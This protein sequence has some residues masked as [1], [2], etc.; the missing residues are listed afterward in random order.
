MATCTL[1]KAVIIREREAITIAQGSPSRPIYDDIWLRSINIE[2]QKTK[3]IIIF[4]QNATD[5]LFDRSISSLK[6]C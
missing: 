3:D 5:A 2:I 6:V 1:E 4:V